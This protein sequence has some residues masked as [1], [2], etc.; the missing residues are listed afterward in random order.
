MKTNRKI[1]L[2][3]TVVVL[4]ALLCACAAPADTH[5][6]QAATCVADRD[7]QTDNHARAYGGAGDP[8]ATAGGSGDRLAAAFPLL[9]ST[10]TGIITISY[11]AQITRR[12]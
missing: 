9:A 11:G 6:G 10:L 7:A 1:A 5:T 2:L 3:L 8:R 4:A 12:C